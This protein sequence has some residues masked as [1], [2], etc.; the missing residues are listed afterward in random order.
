KEEIIDLFISGSF[1]LWGQEHELVA[2]INTADIKLTGRSVYTDEWNYNPVGAA[3]AE[4]NTALPEFDVYD[5]ASQSIDIDQ[6][7]YS[8]YIST[9]LN[10]TDQLSVLLGARTVDIKQDGANY[11]APQA[12]SDKETVPYVG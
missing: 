2:G 4:G 11:G 10:L 7:Q 3:W 5:A 8:Y 9:R 12:A 1:S 6:K